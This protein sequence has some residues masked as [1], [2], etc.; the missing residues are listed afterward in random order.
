MCLFKEYY[1]EKFQVFILVHLCPLRG[2][3]A[4][5]VVSGRVLNNGAAHALKESR[6][7]GL[8]QMKSGHEE[9]LETPEDHGPKEGMVR[10]VADRRGLLRSIRGIVW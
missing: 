10:R 7:D 2:D 3:Y 5:N 8:S 4:A 9:F 6:P 1:W